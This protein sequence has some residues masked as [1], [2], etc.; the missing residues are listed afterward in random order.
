MQRSMANRESSERVAQARSARVSEIAGRAG[1]LSLNALGVLGDAM[2][3]SEPMSTDWLPQESTCALSAR[4]HG[5]RGRSCRS[6]GE[7]AQVVT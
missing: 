6:R 1:D 7:S 4:Q 3:A 2:A 5:W